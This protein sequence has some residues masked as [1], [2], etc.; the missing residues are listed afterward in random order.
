[1]L[2]V[3]GLRKS[4]GVR[5]VLRGVDL[6]AARGEV[7]ALLGPNGAG[8]TTLVSIIAG[9][10]RA[11]AG[12]V[13]VGDVDALTAP[14]A[15]RALLGLAPQ[16][17]GIYPTLSARQ[18][19]ELFAGIAGLRGARGRARIADVAAA[20][21]LT[22]LMD[23]RAGVLSGGQQRRLHT[24]MAMVH[25]PQ[26]LF[27]DEPTVGADV[28]SRRQILDQVRRLADSGCA[29]VY[30]THYL[31]EVEDLDATVAVLV[32]GRIVTTGTVADLVTR[33]ATGGLRLTFDGPPPRLDGFELDG[34]SAYLPT[35][36][37]G[38]RVAA[39]LADAPDWTD[40]LRSVDVARSSLETAYLSIVGVGRQAVPF[41][42]PLHQQEPTH[43][44]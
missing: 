17:L 11:D 5:E 35:D 22:D 41:A 9:L 33:H 10:R 28:E 14:E 36:T 4:Y 39:L 1:M 43:V 31:S 24:A 30:A 27:L 15:A 23:R 12:Q 3:R 25:Q 19:L 38:A 32:D 7:V 40:R 6:D 26:L 29:V 20:L 21:N 13:R 44:A 2:R 42:R 37:P 18:N 34:N 16:A 8:K